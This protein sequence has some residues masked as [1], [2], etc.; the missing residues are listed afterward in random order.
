MGHLKTGKGKSRIAART[1]IISML[2]LLLVLVLITAATTVMVTRVTNSASENFARLYS[3]ETVEKFDSFLARYL[4]PVHLVSGSKPVTEWFTDEE[5]QQ[6][7][8]DAYDGMRNYTNM[9]QNPLLYFV[10]DKSLNEYSVSGDAALNDIVPFDRLDLSVPYNQWY[11]NCVHSKDEYTLNIDI[12][13]VTN[14]AHLWIN[15]KV[16]N[17][18]N[19]AGVF[20][21]GIPLDEAGRNLFAKYDTVNIKGYIIDKNGYIRMNNNPGN[22]Y[23]TETNNGIPET[24]SNPALASAVAKY[25]KNINSYF[26]ANTQ[27]EVLNLGKGAYKFVSIAPIAYSDWSVVTFFNSKSLFSVT[28]LLPL[29]ALMLSAFLLYSLAINAVMRRFLIAPINRLKRSVSEDETGTG[30]LSGHERDDEIGD[31]ARTIR[32]VSIERQYQEQLLHA[33]NSAASMLLATAD[34]ENFNSS[35]QEGMGI[36]GRCVDADRVYILQN[37]LING[38]RY[39]A[40][41]NEWMSETGKQGAT[42]PRGA[43]FPYSLFFETEA[44]F[45]RDKSLNGPI[46]DLPREVKEFFS[47]IDIK[48]ILVIPVFIQEEFWGF[49]SFSDCR[50]ERTFTEDEVNI[51]RSGSLMMVSALNR[52]IQA[53]RLQENRVNTQ[54]LLDAMPFACEL[55]NRDGTIFDCNEKAL[56]LFKVPDKKSYVGNFFDY[57]AKYQADG[58]LATEIGMIYLDRAFEEGRLNFEW[59]RQ[60]TDGTLIPTDVT[61]VRVKFGDR[62]IVVGYARD[63]SMHKQM[64]NEIEQRDNLLNTVNSA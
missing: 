49:V 42:I 31:L 11:T 62:N 19:I 50:T 5:N 59:I 29:L 46:Q 36:M 22:S 64:M 39:F 41:R 48:S 35:L 9:L 30:I 33:V 32:N 26:D 23:Y 58:Q 7:K 18:G 55:W 2:L 25:L 28:N 20:C 21:S 45:S 12:D 63:L 3:I 13:K 6:K 4:L 56:E 16:M 24:A 44:Q 47:R 57:S 43:R 1:R 15:H 37:E 40:Y 8:S 54:I 17:G 27:P 51:L 34:E 53:V 10:I 38:E 52:N 60:S 14:T 61:L